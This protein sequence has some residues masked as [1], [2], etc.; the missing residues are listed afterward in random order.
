MG[1]MGVRKSQIIIVGLDNSG[2][3]TMIN[4]LKPSKYT[5]QEVE[6][7]VGFKLETFIKNNVKFTCFDMSGQSKYRTLW[8]NYYQDCEAI[9][10]VVDA[11]DELRF[12][13]AQNELQ[14]LLEDPSKCPLLLGDHVCRRARPRRAHPLLREQV[15]FAP[16]ARSAEHCDAPRPRTDNRPPLAHLELQR[17]RRH[18]RQRGPQLVDRSAQAQMTWLIELSASVPRV[19]ASHG[20]DL[21]FLL[22]SSLFLVFAF[23]YN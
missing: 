4:F 16:R 10:F 3:S 11:A 7:T 12:A 2:K 15:R 5:Q 21:P 9:I 19:P 18:R 14:L 23:S 6:A 17:S 13:V 20:Q 22:P 1:N 8:G